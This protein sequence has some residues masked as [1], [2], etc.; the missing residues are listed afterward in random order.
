MTEIKLN[1]FGLR[2][3]DVDF[4]LN[5]FAQHKEIEKVIL[6]G[7][8]ARG[9]HRLGSDVDLA[10]IGKTVTFS[11]TNKIHYILEEESPT[12]LWFDVLHFDLLEEGEFK[13]EIRKEGVVIYNKMG[14]IS[15]NLYKFSVT[16]STKKINYQNPQN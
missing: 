13:S 15:K 6:Y 1:L 16:V 8:R 3:K 5:L 12:P 4:M 11:L 2:K 9:T 7:S 10:L 14:E